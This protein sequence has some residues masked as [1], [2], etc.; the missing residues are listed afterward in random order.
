M[1]KMKINV[2]N[3]AFEEREKLYGE[4]DDQGI[5]YWM[6]HWMEDDER[7]R[8]VRCGFSES[9]LL[10]TKETLRKM[11]DLYCVLEDSL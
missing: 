10:I 3:L 8:L 4:L 5:D 9:D 11:N 6:V 7:S 2:K 1:D